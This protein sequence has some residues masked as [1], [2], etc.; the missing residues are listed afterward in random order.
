MDLQAFH[1]PLRELHARLRV[2]SQADQ[3]YLVFEQ[4]I[5]NVVK[6]LKSFT[7]SGF[8]SVFSFEALDR[9]QAM[10]AKVMPLRRRNHMDSFAN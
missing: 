10:F 4:D 6:Q 2:K 3:N 7:D 1:D 9:Q 8:D 5:A